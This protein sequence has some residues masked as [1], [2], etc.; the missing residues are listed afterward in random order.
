MF[1]RFIRFF[2]K[3]PP[4]ALCFSFLV[5]I[6]IGAVFLMLPWASAAGKWT[7]FINALFT[8]TSGICVTGHIVVDTATYWSRFGQGII[9]VLFQLG[10]LGIMIATAL[11]FLVIG[12]RL[13]VSQEG[14][15][16]GML[17]ADSL[18]EAKKLVW[19]IFLTA[20][21]FEFIGFLS[22]LNQQGP[23][24]AL[25]HSA[26]AFCNAGFSLISTSFTGFQSNFAFNLKIT[27]LIIFGGLGFLVLTNLKDV[28]LSWFNRKEKI[29]KRL[30]IHS[31]LVI[32]T[33]LILIVVGTLLFL[34][35]EAKN[36]VDLPFGTK[37]LTSYFQSVTARTAGFNTINIASLTPATKLFL[38]FLMFIG[39]GPGGTAGGIKVTTFVLV[40][41]TV[42]SLLKGKKDIEIF[43]RTVPW[44]TVRKSISIIL[45]SV[46]TLFIL[47]LVLLSFENF[48]FENLLFEVFS[49]FGTVGLS[50]GITPQF[51]SLGKV[52]IIILMYVGR[53]GPL[54]IVALLSRG[55]VMPKKGYPEERVL[56]G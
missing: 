21:T 13:R 24:Q 34:F 47:F 50:T 3:N 12:K 18:A 5:T 44:Q 8:A 30:N 56:V 15:M 28:F 27:T 6:F 49:A 38:M 4:F 31:K 51:S 41:L 54:T 7:S 14:A 45:V 33:S 48:K 32:V 19:F 23:F 10:G 29:K 2:C 46:V 9:F 11:L 43:G 22:L 36:M 40:V 39:G 42:F 37:V 20:F 25:F 26:S 17:E 52:V 53:L 16:K 35:L 55:K 1:N